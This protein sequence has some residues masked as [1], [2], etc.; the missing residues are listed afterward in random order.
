MLST[1]LW[2]NTWYCLN[3]CTFF[4]TLC[5]VSSYSSSTAWEALRLVDLVYVRQCFHCWPF[6]LSSNSLNFVSINLNKPTCLGVASYAYEGYSN[7][8]GS[9]HCLWQYFIAKLPSWDIAWDRLSVCF[10]QNA[11]SVSQA[12][13][14]MVFWVAPMNYLL[15]E[16]ISIFS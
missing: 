13:L 6:Y 16:F 9:M 3:L 14:D 7:K 12:I 10:A 4:L 2:T 8:Y 15:Y 1:W 11:Q 5:R